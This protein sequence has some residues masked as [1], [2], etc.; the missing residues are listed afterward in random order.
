VADA[1]APVVLDVDS[2]LGEDRREA[3][4]FL[5]PGDDAGQHPR[6]TGAVARDESRLGI[7]LE[8]QNDH[9]LFPAVLTV[10]SLA[11]QPKGFD[12]ARKVGLK[13][14]GGGSAS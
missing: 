4:Q 7:G 1:P 13:I 11:A 6:Y 2:L 14:R 5:E 8:P 9:D 10:W 12:F 3:G